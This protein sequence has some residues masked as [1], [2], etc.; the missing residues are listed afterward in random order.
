MVVRGSLRWFARQEGAK[1]PSPV[2]LRNDQICLAN[3][4]S[5]HPKTDCIEA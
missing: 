4:A 5:R 1:L 2:L 3:E